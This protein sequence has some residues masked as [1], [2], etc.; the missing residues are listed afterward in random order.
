MANIVWHTKF[1]IHLDLTLEDL[2][3][4]NLP[5]LWTTIY[6]TDRLYA[7]RS[8]P[9]SERDLQCGGIC[10]QAGVTAWM[11]LRLRANGRR[12]AVHERAEDE[13]RHAA[14]M[15]AEHQ[16]V[17]SGSCVRRRSA[18]SAP[19]ARSA[20]ALAGA[21]GS[22]PTPSSRGRAGCAS[23][24]KSS[25][26]RQTLTAPAA[27]APAPAKQPSTALPPPGTPTAPTTLA[28]T[29]P[30]GPAATGCRRT[31]LP[32][33]A[34]CVSCQ[35]SVCWIFGAAMF[36]PCTA[37]R[38]RRA[39]A[40]GSMSRPSRGMS[41][42]TTSCGGPPRG[43]LCRSS[44]GTG[45]AR[46]V[47]GLP[48]PTGTGS[49]TSTTTTPPSHP[50][51]TTTRTARRVRALVGPL[52]GRPPSPRTLTRPPLLRPTR[53]RRSRHPPQAPRLRLHGRHS[54]QRTRKWCLARACPN[55]C[56]TGELIR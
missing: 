19:I 38:T 56:W 27:S 43:S 33:S 40:A 12:E 14:P 13:E 22:R 8:I 20:P 42:S 52:V 15:T 16:A 4:P 29:T 31:S 5:N 47:S 55:G 54:Q 41:C 35:G 1:G 28:A 24:G 3:H 26:R 17:R 45:R 2:G 37:A 49:R 9:V 18:G 51:P 25:C 53:Y 7:A 48:A 11:Y 44:T 6:D 30:N 36:V 39:G 50:S 10:Q 32:R 46:I 34:I 23:A 21:V